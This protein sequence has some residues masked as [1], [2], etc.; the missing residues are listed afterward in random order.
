M[1]EQLSTA[2]HNPS[3]LTESPTLQPS[4]EGL[5]ASLNLG[6]KKTTLRRAGASLVGQW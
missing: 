3:P 6:V 1:T 5:L 2:Q 4:I